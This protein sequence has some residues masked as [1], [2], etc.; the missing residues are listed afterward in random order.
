VRAEQRDAAEGGVWSR[1]WDE[2]ERRGGLDDGAIDWRKENNGIIISESWL[3]R[4]NRDR[5]QEERIIC[6]LLEMG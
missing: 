1:G 5:D 3:L 4:W 2:R 6:I